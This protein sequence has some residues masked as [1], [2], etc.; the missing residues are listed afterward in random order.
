[1]LVSNMTWLLNNNRWFFVLLIMPVLLLG[2]KFQWLDNIE[3]NNS[4]AMTVSGISMLPTLKPGDRVDVNKSFDSLSLKNGDLVAVQFKT[5]ARPMLKRVLAVENDQV[6]FIDG[7]L[8]LNG[9]WLDTAWWPED[10][11]IAKR[12]YK[13]L[14]LQLSRYH[15]RVPKDNLIVMGDNSA[16]SFDS[17][18]YG[19]ITLSQLAGRIAPASTEGLDLTEDQ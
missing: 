9:E 19:M 6:V 18:D 17:G 16:R 13:L 1:M 15:N 2:I 5:R 3:D 4:Q 10:K 8:K 12:H 7:R 11:R 14:K